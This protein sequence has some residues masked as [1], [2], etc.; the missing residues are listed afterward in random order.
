MYTFIQTQT[1]FLRSGIR[2]FLKI[3]SLGFSI[4]YE[5]PTI[6][7]GLFKPGKHLLRAAACVLVAAEEHL[8]VPLL[9][10]VTDPLRS[11]R[12]HR[13]KTEVCSGGTEHTT[14]LGST[15]ALVS[16]CRAPSHFSRP[17]VQEEF[18]QPSRA[19][20]PQGAPPSRLRLGWLLGTWH[21][22]CSFHFLTDRVGR[23]ACFSNQ[24][25]YAS[26]RGVWDFWSGGV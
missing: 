3:I 2:K 22:D 7:M 6:K 11:P 18:T 13:V 23:C 19:H 20:S 17:P 4:F 5:F 14:G 8:S 9:P 25:I 15:V 16:P 24:A 21:W 26:L 12:F 1:S 10:G